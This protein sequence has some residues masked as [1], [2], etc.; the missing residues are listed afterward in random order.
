MP[1]IVAQLQQGQA[2]VPQQLQQIQQQ[3]GQVLQTQ[4]QMQ[5]AQG[6]VQQAQ[7]QMQQTLGADAADAGPRSAAAC[8]AGQG[9]S[10]HRQRRSDIRREPDAP[11]QS[12]SILLCDMA[13]TLLMGGAVLS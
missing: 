2:G 5:Q 13:P 1:C 12:E 8:G 3:L 7:G 11:A 9:N 10:P 4:G 6:Q